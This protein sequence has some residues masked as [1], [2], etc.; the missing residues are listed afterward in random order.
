MSLFRRRRQVTPPTVP[1]PSPGLFYVPDPELLC[2][3]GRNDLAV[4]LLFST[5]PTDR[6]LR[7]WC[8]LSE[9]YEDVAETRGR[10][11]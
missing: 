9:V 2:D 7:G 4:R 11:A 3:D 6:A 8:G 10:V 5:P 1:V